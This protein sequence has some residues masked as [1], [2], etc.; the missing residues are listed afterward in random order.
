MIMVFNIV[1]LELKRLRDR[2][3]EQKE[4]ERERESDDGLSIGLQTVT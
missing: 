3:A 1:F 4:T 2:S